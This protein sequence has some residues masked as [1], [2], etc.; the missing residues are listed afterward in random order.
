MAKESEVWLTH[1]LTLRAHI[2]SV[3]YRAAFPRSEDREVSHQWPWLRPLRQ[4]PATWLERVRSNMA[5]RDLWPRLGRSAFQVPERDCPVRVRAVQVPCQA[6]AAFC[7]DQVPSRVI[8]LASLVR[9]QEPRAELGLCVVI[10]ADHVPR[11]IFVAPAEAVQE[12]RK[13][14]EDFCGE[15]F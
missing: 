5:W 3:T 8:S 9:V 10:S 15:V 11:K 14:W 12:P 4:E 1:L 13:I 7:A 6:P 2:A